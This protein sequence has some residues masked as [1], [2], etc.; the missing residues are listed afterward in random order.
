MGI[1]MSKRGRTRAMALAAMMLGVS[2]LPGSAASPKADA[3]PA[4]TCPADANDRSICGIS[5]PEDM[6]PL[7]RS[8]WIIVSG[9]A[10]DALYRV[11]TRTRQAVNLV[12][13]VRVRWDR[14]TYADC[15]GPLAPGALTAHGIALT[16]NAAP[17][18]FV[19]NHGS[20]EAI[21]VYRL[22]RQDASLTW[23]GCVPVPADMM[24]NALAQLKSGTLVVTS[25]GKAK[26]NFLPDIIAG[27]P[28][29]GDVRLWSRDKGWRTL[30]YSQGSGPNGLALAPD[31]RSV[32]VAMSGSREIVRLALDGK[33]KPVRSAQ[34]DILPDNLRWTAQGTLITTGMRY[35]PEVNARCFQGQSCQPRFDVYEITPKTLAAKSLS[36]RFETR[37]MP[38]TTTA[39][40]VGG[41]L[42]VSS[43]SG[44]NIA[45]F[46]LKPD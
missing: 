26:T 4:G 11:S 18:L 19:I 28:T 13:G 43:V 30:P 25:L 16:N 3:Q 33:A 42:W 27:R 34:I 14:K 36:G 9:Y 31:E 23:V 45:V 6:A 44:K 20:R 46:P 21:E 24:A 22:R 1:P 2:S 39:L 35:D 5:N 10:P 41:E 15:P 32:Y 38:L 37:P 12:P 29:G 40:R 17:S 8:E 7:A